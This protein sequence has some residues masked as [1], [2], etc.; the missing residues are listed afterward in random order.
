MHPRDSG[1]PA[2]RFPQT[3]KWFDACSCHLLKVAID[4][5][6]EGHPAAARA[7][8]GLAG[9]AV[10]DEGLQLHV[11]LATVSHDAYPSMGDGGGRDGEEFQ[12]GSVHGF[13]RVVGGKGG[14]GCA[15]NAY[16]FFGDAAHLVGAAMA[17]ALARGLDAHAVVQR[18]GNIEI[19]S[20]LQFVEA[21]PVSR[22][23]RQSTF[24]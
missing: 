22:D 15:V 18:A 9:T 7:E 11:A 21:V 5:A 17:L 10:G 3:A 8:P 1:S 23:F 20:D 4:G 12:M 24:P 6:L 19:L 13:L 2:A 14:S 16:P